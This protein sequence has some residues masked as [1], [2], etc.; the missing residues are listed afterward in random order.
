M[1]D[2][3]A[4]SNGNSNNT[5]EWRTKPFLSWTPQ[6]VGLWL[7][8]LNMSEHRSSFEENEITGEHLSSLSKDDLQE[9]GVGR[10]GHRLTIMKAIQQQLPV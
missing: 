7:I 8:G 6:D 4:G 3:F 2:D 1:C 9:L 10:L 5:E